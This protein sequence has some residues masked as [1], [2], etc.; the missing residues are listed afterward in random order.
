MAVEKLTGQRFRA[1]D[2]AAVEPDMA[3][4]TAHRESLIASAK[5]GL[6]AE[7]DVRIG[8]DAPLWKQDP[9]AIGKP[10]RIDADILTLRLVKTP[11]SFT[12]Y[13]IYAS[14]Q[15]TQLLVGY[16][17]VFGHRTA[18]ILDARPFVWGQ[19]PELTVGRKLI[20]LVNFKGDINGRLESLATSQIPALA[21]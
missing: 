11:T 2:V 21:S 15:G 17:I 6:V 3:K 20:R 18:I 16:F 13:L 1:S 19:S 7:E 10:T 5:A 8:L 12:E 14:Y 9:Y 4:V